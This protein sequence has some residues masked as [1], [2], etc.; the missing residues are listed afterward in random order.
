MKIKRPRK[1]EL[2]QLAEFL[3]MDFFPDGIVEPGIIATESGLTYSYGN[4]QE[5]FDGV[6]EYLDRDFHIYLNTHNHYFHD[7]PRTRFT[8]AHEL[9]HY[10]IDE[11]RNA[12][13]NGK[14]LHTSFYKIKREN[15]IEL[16]ADYFASC[17]LMPEE[18]F[19]TM[20]TSRRFDFSLVKSLANSFQTS[21]SATLFRMIEVDTYPFMVVVSAKNRIK[22]S[23]CTEDFP[24]KFFVNHGTGKL[25][26]LT[27]AG[28]YFN[29]GER[30]D[31]TEEVD[32]QR[33]FSS[34]KEDLQGVTLYEKCIYQ[35]KPERVISILW[36]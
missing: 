6:L 4:Y 22:Y 31:E 27:A 8:F 15:I 14:S 13:I 20:A 29:C 23:W 1:R 25:P 26:Q 19:K 12:L 3:A 28:D 16:E 32:A 30:Y 5:C 34:Y 17:L 2:N 35:S 36:Q 11:H 24:Y 21:L 9:G 10:F 18:R 7:N 33:W